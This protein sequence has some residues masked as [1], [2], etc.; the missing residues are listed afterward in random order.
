MH[1]DDHVLLFLRCD[2]P[3]RIDFGPVE[4]AGRKEPAFGFENLSFRQRKSD[5]QRSRLLAD[6]RVLCNIVS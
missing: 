1:L 6:E 2:L 5:F 3:P 4:Y